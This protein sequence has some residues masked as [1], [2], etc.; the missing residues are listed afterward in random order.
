MGRIGDGAGYQYS[1][2]IAPGR[3]LV[4]GFDT[5]DLADPPIGVDDDLA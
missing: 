2:K 4:G 1:L 3:R 5:F